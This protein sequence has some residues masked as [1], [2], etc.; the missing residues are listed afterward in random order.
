MCFPIKNSKSAVVCVRVCV[1][2][3][4]Y[5]AQCASCRSS[6]LWMDPQ[7]TIIIIIGRTQ[8]KYSD[9]NK[10][11]LI[12]SNEF[13]FMSNDTHQ[14]VVL[15]GEEFSTENSK[16]SRMDAQKGKGESTSE[17]TATTKIDGRR[18]V[19]F[20][21]I[22]CSSACSSR[23]ESEHGW[24]ND[25]TDPLGILMKM[26]CDF[27]HFAHYFCSMRALPLPF[28]CIFRLYSSVHVQQRYIC[29]FFVRDQV[30]GWE[31]T[32]QKSENEESRMCLQ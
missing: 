9:T 5:C 18:W 29:S 15:I 25:R 6:D 16:F 12:M 13:K 3:R 20:T 21:C 17:T 8:Y 11:T 27:P 14:R 26:T 23:C 30:T 28:V 2:S 22:M 1:W 31:E 32:L 4:F 19:L 7:Q 10:Q 24:V